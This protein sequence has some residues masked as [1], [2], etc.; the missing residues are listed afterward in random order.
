MYFQ[1]SLTFWFENFNNLYPKPGAG[2]SDGSCSCKAVELWEFAAR[3]TPVVTAP[4]MSKSSWS[5][6]PLEPQISIRSRHWF[7]IPKMA[8]HSNGFPCF[9][10]LNFKHVVCWCLL[11]IYI[12][13]CTYQFQYVVDCS[14]LVASL[15][16][17]RA[18]QPELKLSRFA[19]ATCRSSCCRCTSRFVCP[20]FRRASRITWWRPGLKRKDGNCWKKFER[21]SPHYVCWRR[22]KKLI[23]IFLSLSHLK[24]ER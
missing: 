12:Y 3:F 19:V 24:K 13:T 21:W 7:P 18:V 20:S 9:T 14:F 2:E 10:C 22:W 8:A 4:R 5:A 6:L 23:S 1:L 11:Y 15:D 17:M 16:I